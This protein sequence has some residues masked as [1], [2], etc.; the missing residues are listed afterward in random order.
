[1]VSVKI[2]QDAYAIPPMTS[3]VID[4]ISRPDS[5]NEHQPLP[6]TTT[7]IAIETTTTTTLPLPPQPQQSTTD[8]ILI[9]HI[10]KRRHES[11]KTPPGSPPHQPPPPP[12][13]AGPS[14]TSGSSCASGLSQLPPPPPPLSN[15]QNLPMN[16][17]SA[18]DEQWKPLSE[19]D[20]P[21]TPEPAWSI[22]SSDLPV[23]MNN[24][25]S[26]LASTYEPPPRTRYLLRPVTWQCLWTGT[27]K[28]KGSLNLNKKT[29]KALHLKLSKSS[30][31]I[32]CA[33]N[34][35][36]KFSDGT[37]HQIDE[38]LDYRVKEF[39][40]QHEESGFEHMVIEQG[41]MFERRQGVHVFPFKT[42]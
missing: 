1:M 31:L 34:E 28:S 17:D 41:K 30:I 32:S 16:D 35:I 26:A 14:R 25:A 20:K 7:A 24:W 9:K 39:Q 38:A 12:P 19:E 33:V 8:S 10:K 4:P 40:G 18:P 6:A 23:L 27:V 13:P 11:P 21:T 5:P 3:P 37:L 29:W 2:H 15:N 42:T 36:H 22:P